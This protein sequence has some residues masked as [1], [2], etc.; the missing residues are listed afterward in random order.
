MTTNDFYK[1]L[2]SP[3]A[4]VNGSEQRAVAVDGAAIKVSL[5]F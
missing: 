1:R 3:R 4:L 5:T 2:A